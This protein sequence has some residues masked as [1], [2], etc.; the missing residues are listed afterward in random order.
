MC[1]RQVQSSTWAAQV[2]HKPGDVFVKKS[3]N[4]NKK[5]PKKYPT[6]FFSQI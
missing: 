1:K 4:D 5:S 6:Q 3:P 2:T